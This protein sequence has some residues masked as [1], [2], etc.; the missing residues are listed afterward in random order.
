M[1]PSD[2]AQ[3]SALL[4]FHRLSVFADAFEMA[5][6]DGDQL[7][8]LCDDDLLELGR[9]TGD[10]FLSLKRRRLLQLIDSA[11]RDGVPIVQLG[12]DAAGL[13]CMAV[14]CCAPV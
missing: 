6:L 9:Q 10:N 8:G 11:G 13:W 3:V 12:G 2:R 1:A 14:L 7:L 5:E 4:C